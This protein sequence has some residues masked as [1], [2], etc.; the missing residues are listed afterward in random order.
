[1]VYLIRDFVLTDLGDVVGLD[2]RAF[3]PDSWNAD[4]FGELYN[5]VDS[6]FLVARADDRFVGYVCGMVYTVGARDMEGYVASIAVDLESRR[7]GLGAALME[8]IQQRFVEKGVTRLALHVR[9]TNVA[10]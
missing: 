3:G 5:H 2:Q 1:M 4:D 6:T 9:T 7:A 10:A 8:A